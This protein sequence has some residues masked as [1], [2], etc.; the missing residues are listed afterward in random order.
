[1]KKR[2]KESAVWREEKYRKITLVFNSTNTKGKG[3]ETDND[4]SNFSQGGKFLSQHISSFCMLSEDLKFCQVETRGISEGSTFAPFFFIYIY[5]VGDVVVRVKF[6]ILN[7]TI[8][9]LL[10]GF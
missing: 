2:G 7:N 8:S 3:G 1:M 9:E 4:R 10:I 6:E 5:M